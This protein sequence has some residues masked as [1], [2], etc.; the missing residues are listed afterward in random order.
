[1][2]FRFFEKRFWV[3]S[4]VM[5]ALCAVPLAAN[6]VV[7]TRTWQTYTTIQA[8]I[9]AASGGD[10][11]QVSPGTYAENITVNKAVAIVGDFGRT[12]VIDGGTS[13]DVFTVTA[14]MA[15]IK[16]LTIKSR[17]SVNYTCVKIDAEK[18]SVIGNNILDCYYG[19][20]A[21][22]GAHSNQIKENELENCDY[23]A[24]KIE[25]DNNIVHYN[26]IHDIYRGLW[27]W[28]YA[29]TGNVFSSNTISDFDNE[30]ILTFGTENWIYSNVI[31]GDGTSSTGDHGMVMI[32][33]TYNVITAN[34]FRDCD[35]GIYMFNNSSSNKIHH[36]NFISN[37]CH[38]VSD[39]VLTPS[40]NTWDNGSGGNY[41]SGHTGADANNDGIIDNTPYPV[42]NQNC[43]GQV[44]TDTAP[45][46]S[47]WFPV[48]GNINGSPDGA[49]TI[50]DITLLSTYLLQGGT[51][52][53]VPPC[54]GDVNGDGRV[55]DDATVYGDVDYL[56]DYMFNQGPAPVANACFFLV[57]PRFFN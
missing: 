15:M 48:P 13:G 32:G 3:I 36:N 14:D 54:V 10:T 47:I 44:D 27:I 53:P 30:G 4:L 51:D 43:I 55:Y 37:T 34:T 16:F 11:L 21:V 28:G 38:A 19:I 9:N 26:Y 17:T 57:L 46:V 52:D 8:A 49:I 50:G 7:N 20:H 42:P 40:I 41:W 24:V 23:A 18:V 2:K 6:Q 31:T 1:M 35:Y 12:P 5:I 29:V 33:A 56:L 45:L 22:P 39:T 25:S